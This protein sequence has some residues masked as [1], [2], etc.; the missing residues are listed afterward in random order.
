MPIEKQCVEC[1]KKFLVDRA[2]EKSASTCSRECRGKVD[3][4]KYREARAKLKCLACGS[5]FLA[6]QCHA[7]RRKFCS[8][9]CA[10]PARKLNRPSGDQ[11]YLWKGGRAMHGD[12]YLYVS[13]RGHPFTKNSHYVL[14]H[15]IVVEQWM[16]EKA[17]GHRFL[18]VVDG[19]AYLRPGIEVHHINFKRDDNRRQN[20]LACTPSAHK[21][22]HCGRAPMKGE[23]WPEIQG[24]VPYEP[25][26]VACKCRVCAKEFPKKL[27]DVKRGSGKF[28]SRACYQKRVR[29][30]FE[31][32]KT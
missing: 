32:V 28:C 3:A 25:R 21:D 20:L 8:A 10:G 13:V 22:I 11:H 26:V 9:E 27:C 2:R 17:P 6:P 14:E 19:V 4:Q 24:L 12:G 29:E 15:R 16:R 1:K 31:I 7:K 18:T 5:Q 23:V 30:T